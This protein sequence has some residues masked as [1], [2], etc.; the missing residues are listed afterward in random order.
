M[1]LRLLRS[2]PIFSGLNEEDLERIA[3]LCVHK[4]CAPNQLILVEEESGQSLF[5]I[6]RGSVKV[7]H[8]SDE[9]RE[10]ILSILN[11]GDFFG[12]MA[13]LD[14][15]GRSANVTALVETELLVLRRGDFLGLLEDYPQIS[16]ALLRELAGRIRRS[17]SHI[18]A[19]SLKDA[20][21]RVAMALVHVAEKTG[22]PRGQE[23]IIPK[24]PIQQ[25]LAN[26]AGTARETISRAMGQFEEMGYLQREGHRVVIKDFE[27][28]KRAFS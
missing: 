22:R 7:S 8:V 12:E 20:M 25:D 2:I 26:M 1:D 5:I 6:K 15:R 24:L 18:S 28:F 19:L 27:A 13:L 21:G 10:V 11:A 9:G 4:T 3:Q 23:M 17:D 14:G 16:I